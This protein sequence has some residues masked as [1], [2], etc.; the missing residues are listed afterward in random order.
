MSIRDVAEL[1]HFRELH[2]LPR[3]IFSIG[4]VCFLGAF[5]LKSFLLG[6][7]GVGV[8]FIG[9]TLNFAINFLMQTD[10]SISAKI[11]KV[12]W[13]MLFQLMLSALISYWLIGVIWFYYRYGEMPPYLHSLPPP[14]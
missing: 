14:H 4:V 1:V 10:I 7:F 5:F 8:I 6:F 13:V 3:T 11:F 12:A 2:L 9:L